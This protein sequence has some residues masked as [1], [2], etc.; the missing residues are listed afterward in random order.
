MSGLW[1]ARLG[2]GQIRMR[3]QFD[4]MARGDREA[5]AAADAGLLAGGDMIDGI[6][7]ILDALLEGIEIG[8]GGNLERHEIDAG[9]IGAA[10]DDRMM[11]ELL[12][13]FQIDAAVGAFG[14]LMQPD[15][16]G[17]M[18]DRRRH[19]EHANLDEART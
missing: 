8:V 10:Q 9:L 7:V 2:I 15:A 1:I 5:D 12:R 6:A 14:H 16:L 17:V 4:A 13:R 18:L 19:V 3:E 11:I